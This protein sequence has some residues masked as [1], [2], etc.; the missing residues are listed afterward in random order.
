MSG[1]LADLETYARDLRDRAAEVVRAETSDAAP[2]GTA[3]PTSPAGYQPGGLRD[4]IVL[5]DQA[6]NGT[7]FSVTIKA[8]KEYAEFTDEDTRAHEIVSNP[9][10]PK[11]RF[12]WENGPAGEGIYVFN[13]VFHPGTTGTHW[14]KDALPERWERALEQEK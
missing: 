3:T 14:F 2:V 11:L 13:S 6:D 10:G 12:W 1:A 9:G 8:D 7:T 5:L 4:S